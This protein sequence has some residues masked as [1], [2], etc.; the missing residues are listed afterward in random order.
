MA[1]RSGSS[2]GSYSY[3]QW[4]A[5]ERARQRQRKE[6]EKERIATQAEARDD[7]AADKTEEVEDLVAELEALLRSSLPRDPR[8][9]FNSMRRSPAIPPLDLGSLAVPAPA[10]QW[11]DFEPPPPNIMQRALGGSRR[12][13]RSN[14]EAQQAFATAQQDHRAH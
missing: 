10:P 8:I 6:A 4:E 3:R 5:A 13:Q 9:S 7:E 11:A 14:A 1:R 2:G 12:H